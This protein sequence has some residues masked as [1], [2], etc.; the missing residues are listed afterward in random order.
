MSTIFGGNTGMTYEQV[1]RQRKIADQL[2]SNNRTPRNVGEGLSAIGNALAYR[3]ITKRAD[4]RDSELRGEYNDMASGVFGGMFGG[5]APT[6][7]GAGGTYTPPEAP[8]PMDAMYPTGQEG[9]APQGNFD[10]ASGTDMGSPVEMDMATGISQTA[11]ALG[12]DPH[13]LATIISYETAGSF[14]PSQ[15]GPTTQWGQHK[16][17]IQFGEPQAQQYGVNWDDPLGSQLGADGAIVKYFQQNGWKPGMGIKDA[18][19]IVN[20]GAPGRFNASDAN[21]GGAPGTVGEKVDNQFAGHRQKAAELLGGTYTPNAQQGQDTRTAQAGGMDLQTLFKIANSPYAKP[22]EKAM[23]QYQIQQQMS[24]NDPSAQLDMQYKQAQLNALQA[25]NNGTGGSNLPA[26]V[27]EAQ[28]RAKQAG[29]VEG[30]PEYEAFIL[31]SGGDPATFRALDMQAKAAGL[32]EGSP[33]YSEF[34]A[35]RGVGLQAEAKTTATNLANIETGGLANQT[36]S[37]GTKV[38]ALNAQIEKGADAAAETS[39]GAAVGKADAAAGAELR[40][41]E[42][43]MPG[44]MVVVEQLDG[45]AD[46]AT[47][48][49]AGQARDM[50]NKQLG[51]EAGEGAVA[52]AE[53]IAIV[54]NQVLPL[55]RQTFGAAF[56]AKEG[57]T[58]KNTLGDPNKS[59]AEKK[60]VLRAFIAQKERDLMARRGGN[61]TAAQPIDFSAMTIAD[62]GQIDIGSLSDADMDALEARMTELGL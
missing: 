42:R 14:D 37:F 59:P 57:E 9:P 35:T 7:G 56:T 44:L 22:A 5:P 17:L 45:L 1:Q 19:S 58:L 26:A 30:T 53:Y 54:D 29:L 21:N 27:I 40:E 32:V 61:T 47:Y 24:A 39:R 31:N 11:E 15:K 60:A 51:M 52:R 62:V 13:D 38:G 6:S 36:L 49:L 46:I 10:A 20:A 2:I 3:G 41:M 34:M 23:A 28:W 25:K 12:M 48:T 18:Y 55:L 8:N 33:E 4:K 43:N 16:G 50:A